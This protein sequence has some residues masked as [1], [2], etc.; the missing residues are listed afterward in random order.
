MTKKTNIFIGFLILIIFLVGVWFVFSKEINQIISKIE[1]EKLPQN[2]QKEIVLVI[3]D[4]E[5][6]PKTFK[7]EVREEMT[8]LDLLKIG[9][10]K[11]NLPLKT[12][13]YDIGILVE[14]IGN[15]ENGQD[16]KYWLY[17]LNG[18]MPTVAVNKQLIKGGDKVEFK[19]EKSPF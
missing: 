10:K 16:N 18:E 19:F 8:T 12:K 4:G 17:Y 13:T 14:A 5:G 1:T 3:D 11:M 15:K 6:I 2:N 9:T 7:T